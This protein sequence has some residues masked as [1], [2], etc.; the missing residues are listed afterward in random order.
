M[1]DKAY[2]IFFLDKSSHIQKAE[3]VYCPDDVAAVTTART[4]ASS[5]TVEV[6][7]LAHHLATLPPQSH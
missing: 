7:H 3:V 2:R 4:K 1:P 6:W 5:Y